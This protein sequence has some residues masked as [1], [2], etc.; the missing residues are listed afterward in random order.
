MRLSLRVCQILEGGGQRT[1]MDAQTCREIDKAVTLTLRD[2][3]LKEPPFRIEDVLGHLEV[4]RG[5]YDLEDPTLLRRFWHKVKVKKERPVK[6]IKK[7]KL[8]AVWLPDE[9]HILIDNSLPAPKQEWAA[10]HDATH[11]ILEWHRPYFL[12]DTAQTPDPD[13]QMMLESEANYG[14][15]AL[16]F[17]EKIFTREAMDTVPVWASIDGLHTKGIPL[18]DRCRKCGQWLQHEE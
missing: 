12:G 13:F 9:E 1:L 6:V 16:M 17:G 7:I 14:A 10:Y 3:G 15:S 2:A 11:S 18:S 4:H 8:A 5:F